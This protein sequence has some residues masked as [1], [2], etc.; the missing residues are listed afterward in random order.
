VKQQTPVNYALLGIEWVAVADEAEVAYVDLMTRSR[1]HAS[2]L[3]DALGVEAFRFTR[4]NML[5]HAFP[6]VQ[7]VA[8]R[9]WLEEHGLAFVVSPGGPR[10]D[11]PM[12]WVQGGF[13]P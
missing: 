11:G 4:G 3:E 12:T 1:A 8:A 2:L 7:A 9:Q 13:P 5:L 10:E 6:R